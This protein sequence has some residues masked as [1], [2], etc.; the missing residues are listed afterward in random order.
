MKDAFKQGLD[1]HAMTASEMFDTPIEGMDPMIRRRA[2]AINFGI[3]YGISAFGLARQLSI[4]RDEAA[5]YIK[6]YF[7]RF[8]GIKAYMDETKKYAAEHERVETI[9]GRVLHL[10]GIKA[11]GPATRL[12]RA[13]G[14]QCANPGLSRRHHQAGDDPYAR[15]PGSSRT[16]SQD[17]AASA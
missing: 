4:P 2:K 1:I 8:P 11:K 10:K 7:K 9:F 14:D 16:Q 6:T 12:C 5:A 15:R 17:A 3:I 13:P